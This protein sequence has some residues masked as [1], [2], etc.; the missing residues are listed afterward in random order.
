MSICSSN[1]TS[2]NRIVGYR[3]RPTDEELVGV[4]LRSKVR[5]SRD[6]HV[7]IITLPEFNNPCELEPWQFPGQSWPPEIDPRNRTWYF[8][9][10]RNPNSKRVKRVTKAGFWSI[11]GEPKPIREAKTKNEIGFKRIMTFYFKDPVSNKKKK[12][13]KAPWVIHEYYLPD[14]K[15]YVL[16]KLKKKEYETA[17]NSSA[18]GQPSINLPD[19]SSPEGQA[20]IPEG[21]T[22][23]RLPDMLSPEGQT[24]I[25]LPDMLSPEGQTSICLPN[26]LSP[27]GYTS[28][29]LP[30]PLSPEG[31]PSVPDKSSPEG[32]MNMHFPS[33]LENHALGDQSQEIFDGIGADDLQAPLMANNQ[34][35]H[36]IWSM[37]YFDSMPDFDG[38]DLD[39][40]AFNQQNMDVGNGGSGLPFFGAMSP[41]SVES[42]LKRSRVEDGGSNTGAETE[43]VL[44]QC[45]WL[46]DDHAGSSAFRQLPP[47]E[48]SSTTL[49]SVQHPVQEEFRENTTFISSAANTPDFINSIALEEQEYPVD[50]RTF[51]SQYQIKNINLI[52]KEPVPERNP[53]KLKLSGDKAGD[54]KEPVTAVHLPQNEDAVRESNIDQKTARETSPKKR[55]KMQS[56][57]SASSDRKDIFIFPETSPLMHKPS[58]PSVYIFNALLGIILF[59]PSSGTWLWAVILQVQMCIES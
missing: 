14:N 24:S 41:I 15:N 8:F 10:R 3:F 55:L 53:R 36:D 59:I 23:V 33:N 39:S 20:N 18:E 42:S 43:V 1:S 57:G 7:Q 50:M 47:V 49:S 2:S 58:P 52:D 31:Q 26:M 12:E 17:D 25:R 6:S 5:G 40:T 44:T 46:E 35:D 4:Y 54:V 22:S 29:Y 27:E 48:V 51:K 11:T 28:V 56:N 37:L 32:Q 34:E 19:I 38:S 45:F 21:Q 9:C 16:C 30:H 13:N